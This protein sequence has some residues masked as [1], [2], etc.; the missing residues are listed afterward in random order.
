MNIGI[1]TLSMNNV[2]NIDRKIKNF[3]NDYY[4]NIQNNG[5]I[6]SNKYFENSSSII[7]DTNKFNFFEYLIHL[8]KNEVSTAKY[9]LTR[10]DWLVLDTKKVL[11]V[12]SGSMNFISVKNII[13][14]NKTF[15]DIMI[16]DFSKEK[17]INLIS[18]LC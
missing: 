3:V 12:V 1:N 6:E 2:S 7:F 5:F 15:T 18:N 11:I 17:I 4:Q 16:I 10:Y 9:R 8:I 13:G 14:C